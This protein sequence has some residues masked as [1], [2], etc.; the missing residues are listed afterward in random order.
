MRN[1]KGGEQP[2]C[3]NG[4]RRHADMNVSGQPAQGGKRHGAWAIKAD[5]PAGALGNENAKRLLAMPGVTFTYSRFFTC[6][7]VL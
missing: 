6:G 4:V 7:G 2:V 3:P 1:E 5:A